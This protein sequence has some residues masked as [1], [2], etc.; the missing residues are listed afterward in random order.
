MFTC[1]YK[2][3]ENIIIKLVIEQNRSYCADSNKIL[4]STQYAIYY[5]YICYTTMTD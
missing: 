1:M 5:I 4:R 2:K 3:S